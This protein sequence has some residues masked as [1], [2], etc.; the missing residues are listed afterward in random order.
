MLPKLYEKESIRNF[1]RSLNMQSLTCCECNGEGATTKHTY[2]TL[3]LKQ[4]GFKHNCIKPRKNR[5]HSFCEECRIR[6]MATAHKEPKYTPPT[7]KHRLS[8]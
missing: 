8:W 6:L 5:R 3:D 1:R 2:S 7:R 4:M